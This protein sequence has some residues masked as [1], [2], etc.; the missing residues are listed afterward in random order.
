[1]VLGVIIFFMITQVGTAQQL[2]RQYI[3]NYNGWFAYSGSHKISDKWGLHL[4]VQ[5]RRSNLIMDNQQLLM[6]AGINHYLNSQ[7]YVTAGYCYVITYPYGGFAAKTMFPENRIWEQINLKTGIGAVEI[8]N[9]FRLEQRY[10][11]APVQQDNGIYEPGD[12]IYTNRARALIRFYLP[13]KG[14]TIEDRSWFASAFNEVFINFGKNVGYN[15][16]DQNRAYLGIGYKLPKAGRLELGYL[17]QL[18]LK[19]DGIKMER[20]HT[21]QI[22]L[23]SSIEFRKK[24]E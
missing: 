11:N 7:V 2:K 13:F 12:A 24:K 1:M 16:L 23:S 3:N 20:N 4:E 8:I 5:W 15:I 14:K 19:N 17:N 22:S 18:V 21:I 6:R 10:I 9:R